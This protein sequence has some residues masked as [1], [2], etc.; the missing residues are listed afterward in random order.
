MNECI[1]VEGDEDTCAKVVAP[2][3]KV[4]L[5]ALHYV[6]FARWTKRDELVEQWLK[7]RS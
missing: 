6:D 1:Y 7:E 2:G 5:C 3:L 4:S